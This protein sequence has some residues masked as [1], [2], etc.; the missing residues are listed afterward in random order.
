VPVDR[1]DRDAL[2]AVAGSRVIPTLVLQ[3]GAALIDE[4]EICAWLADHVR[5]PAG[6][7]RHRA[8][9]ES[10]HRLEVDRARAERA[11]SRFPDTTQMEVSR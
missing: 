6:A 5:S 4:G 1:A 8:K 9:A 2:F 3:N 11:R 7:S 10:I